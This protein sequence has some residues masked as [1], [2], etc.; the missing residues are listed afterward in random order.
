VWADR[1]RLRC[2]RNLYVSDTNNNRV[3]EY[4]TPL[5]P[6][7][8]E[9]GAADSI[10]DNVFGQNGSFVTVGDNDGG[11]SGDV[12]GLG[13]DSLFGAAGTCD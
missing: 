13:R 8:G 2:E 12:A 6:S 3:L 9:S 11:G 1:R 5:N 10:A 4:N 7:S